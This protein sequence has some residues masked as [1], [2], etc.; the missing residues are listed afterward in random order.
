[1]SPD[2]IHEADWL[3]IDELGPLELAGKGWAP[4]I[5]RILREDPKPMIWTVRRQL[6]AKIAHKWN[7]GEVT[8][9]DV[10]KPD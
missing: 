9:I 2:N 4:L 3:V 5:E 8:I 7:I 10:G 1:M 6:A